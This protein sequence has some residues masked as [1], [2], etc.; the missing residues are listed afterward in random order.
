[1][2]DLKELTADEK[3]AIAADGLLHLPKTPYSYKRVLH[4]NG[5]ETVTV[6]DA[7]GKT[8][9]NLRGGKKEKSALAVLIVE[10]SYRTHNTQKAL[11]TDARK[12]GTICGRCRGTGKMFQ[13]IIRID[14]RGCEEHV[15][16]GRGPCDFPGCDRGYIY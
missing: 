3:A 4:D 16:T 10:A 12:K 6:E 5:S 1:M 11:A 9:A 14:D 15:Y 8:V 7:D 2:F 13:T